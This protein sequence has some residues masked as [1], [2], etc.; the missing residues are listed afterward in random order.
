MSPCHPRLWHATCWRSRKNVLMWKNC[1]EEAASSV[2]NSGSDSNSL[3]WRVPPGFN[4]GPKWTGVWRYPKSNHQS[5]QMKCLWSSS[6][7]LRC[8]CENLQS[9]PL[10]SCRDSWQMEWPVGT[11]SL[12]RGDAI[13]RWEG[14]GTSQDLKRIP[15][16]KLWW[17]CSWYGLVLLRH[18]SFVIL[19]ILPD[20]HFKH[21][22]KIHPGRRIYICSLM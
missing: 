22:A 9:R 19:G 5:E 10:T 7:H 18:S 1:R 14:Q 2:K 15:C 12:H 21:I 16:G 20:F 11:S 3:F 4:S 8:G 17:F 13:L 6:S